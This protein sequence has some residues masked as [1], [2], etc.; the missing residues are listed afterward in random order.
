M[1]AWMGRLDL[2][3]TLPRLFGGA[4]GPTRLMHSR[5]NRA[6]GAQITNSIRRT[7][8]AAMRRWY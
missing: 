8:R 3:H 7:R 2:D 5:C 6:L 4:G 1:L